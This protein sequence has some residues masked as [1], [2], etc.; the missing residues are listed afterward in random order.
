[1]K[2]N[3]LIIILVILSIVFITLGLL[4]FKNSSKETVKYYRCTTKKEDTG[5]FIQYETARI[6]YDKD[7]IITKIEA[8]TVYKIDDDS[9]YENMIKNSKEKFID[10]YKKDKTIKSEVK[11]PSDIIGK[12]IEYILRH[13]KDAKCEIKEDK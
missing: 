13:Y 11:L 9:V 6:D 3:N 10:T 12:D 8:Y 5:F 1:M 7:N 4:L 2:R